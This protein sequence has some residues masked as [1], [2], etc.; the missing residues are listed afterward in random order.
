MKIETVN[1]NDLI[2]PD[3]NPRL[4]SEEEMNKLEMSLKNYGYIDPIIVNRYN[5]HIVG[6]NQRYEALKSLGYKDIDVIFI[7]EPDL[8]REKA[9]NLALNKISGE[10]DT[11]KLEIILDELTSEGFDLDLTGFD[12]IEL[13]EM[14]LEKNIPL[15][16][17][18]PDDLDNVTD[19]L[20]QE[21]K[22]KEKKDKIICPHCG[23]EIQI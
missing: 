3:F 18:V 9:L 12:K 5:N 8:N 14:S 10:W 20:I 11:P 19:D 6:G 13:K 22:E 17:D 2:S 7:D 23:N 16:E 4:M 1:I 21:Q 15:W